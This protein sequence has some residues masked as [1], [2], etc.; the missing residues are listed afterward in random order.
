MLH[1]ILDKRPLAGALALGPAPARLTA[2]ALAS[3][4]AAA[5]W[6]QAAQ[7]QSAAPTQAAAGTA[8]PPIP[9]GP[10]PQTFEQLRVA[11]VARVATARR[12][13]KA[14]SAAEKPQEAAPS[15]EKLP[16]RPKFGEFGING[17][18]TIIFADGSRGAGA[19]PGDA[20]VRRLAQAAKK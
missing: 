16:I 5:S 7:A 4:L 20:L 17:T 13:R 18:P 14:L 3:T 2:L 11:T 1:F 6:V 10:L 8:S 9:P 19:M 12:T 15:E